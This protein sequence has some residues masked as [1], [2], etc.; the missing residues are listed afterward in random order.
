MHHWLK[1]MTKLKKYAKTVHS[2]DSNLV[3][4]NGVS[5]FRWEVVRQQ[6]WLSFWA[7]YNQKI[8]L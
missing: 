1:I 3:E 6:I 4:I 7:S 8:E 5:M 2:K